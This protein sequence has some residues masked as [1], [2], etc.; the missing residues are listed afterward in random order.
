MCRI[1]VREFTPRDFPESVYEIW[2]EAFGDSRSEIGHILSASSAIFTASID[3]RAAAEKSAPSDR[4]GE[5]FPDE[6]NTRA[7]EDDA[8]NSHCAGMLCTFDVSL[9]GAR[10]AYIYA[11]CT[12]RRYRGMGVM[13]ALITAVL[14]ILR[15]RGMS[16]AFLVPARR[17]YFPMYEKL[18]FDVCVPGLSGTP[19]CGGVR[20]AVGHEEF[21]ALRPTAFDGDFDRLYSLYLSSPQVSP[22]KG[23]A[24][25]RLSVEEYADGG[26]CYTRAGGD[27]AEPDGYVIFEPNSKKSINILEIRRCY[28]AKRGIISS[29]V[30]A[31]EANTGANAPFAHSRDLDIDGLAEMSLQANVSAR[32]E[33]GA[34]TAPQVTG[35]DAP[36]VQPHGYAIDGLA[37]MS[38]QASLSA[39]GEIGV[40]TALQVTGANAPTVQPHG[41][42]IDGLAEMSLQ[43]NISARGEIG[44]GTVS[45]VTGDGMLPDGG[46]AG[47][48][49]GDVT[50]ADGDFGG[51]DEDRTAAQVGQAAHERL[52]GGE[53][54]ESEPGTAFDC[55]HR[56]FD[57]GDAHI[58]NIG[59]IISPA[60]KQKALFVCFG[61]FRPGEITVDMF[62][63]L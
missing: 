19:G 54:C 58:Y 17:E 4:G 45:Q 16:F 60:E 41:Y 37:E 33:I 42:A 22:T 53:S 12:R 7:E 13:R 8:E 6:E 29:E 14:G 25:F 20:T 46:C 15:S 48:T 5:N 44:A 10:G 63:E 56:S 47:G 18:G 59:R 27:D 34:G 57:G 62:M 40:G 51:Y 38:L 30:F 2:H 61:G 50:H 36:T 23:K 1:S 21:D 11:V 26:I 43:A 32:G 28:G 3:D 9:N 55:T 39:R 52:S 49:F 24:L 35:A 31:G